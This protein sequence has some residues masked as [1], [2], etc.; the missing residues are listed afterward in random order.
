MRTVGLGGKCQCRGG[1]DAVRGL[2]L[3]L[4]TNEQYNNKYN[5]NNNNN[6]F[7]QFK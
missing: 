3:P 7:K 2:A 1:M 4:I 5:T 6:N